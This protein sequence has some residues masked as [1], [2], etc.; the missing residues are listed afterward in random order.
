MLESPSFNWSLIPKNKPPKKSLQS[1]PPLLPALSRYTLHKT[2]GNFYSFL[3]PLCIFK[4]SSLQS[5]LHSVTRL[6]FRKHN[7]DHIL[8]CP[9]ASDHCLWDIQAPSP[10]H[11][12]V[13]RP[14]CSPLFSSWAS[15][16]RQPTRH[17]RLAGLQIIHLLCQH[18]ALRVLF[19]DLGMSFHVFFWSDEFLYIPK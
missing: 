18:W 7:F 4:L 3:S 16:H 13:S 10:A 2:L 12:V 8:S 6:I 19:L 14:G 9:E 5:F 1:V 17:P 11:T 15:S